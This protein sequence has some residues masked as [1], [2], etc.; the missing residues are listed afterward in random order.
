MSNFSAKSNNQPGNPDE[1]ADDGEINA[2]LVEH[3]KANAIRPAATPGRARLP[4]RGII[5]EAFA[6]LGLI[7]LMVV[8][9]LYTRL[10]GKEA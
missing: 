7:G 5:R 1:R 10:V 3:I 6:V 2:R 4:S 8:A 9:Y